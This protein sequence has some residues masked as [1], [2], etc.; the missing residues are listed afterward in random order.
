M[1]GRPGTGGEPVGKWPVGHDVTAIVV[2]YRSAATIEACLT[3]LEHALDP[4]S[5]EIIVVDNAS[6]DDTTAVVRTHLRARLICR[7]SNAGFGTAVNDGLRRTRT[8]YALV[9]NDDAEVDGACVVRLVAALAPNP[10]IGLVGPIVLDADG[11]ALASALAF[12]PG[13]LE[14]QDRFGRAARRL[15]RLVQPGLA[16]PTPRGNPTITGEEQDVSWLVGVALL[17]RSDVLRRLGG[18]NQA[19]FLYG[20]EID[21]GQRVAVAG[22]RNVWVTAATC[23]HPVGVGTSNY[24]WSRRE[25]VLRRF[26][27]QTTYDRI[28]LARRTRILL[29]LLR[30]TARSDQPLRA[31]YHLGAA[32]WDGP[33]LSDLRTLLPLEPAWPESAGL[34]G[35]NDGAALSRAWSPEGQMQQAEAGRHVPGPGAVTLH[36]Q[37]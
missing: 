17:G 24:I 22:L 11:N 26:R 16:P 7:E 25:R 12:F 29:N 10:D 34:G 31:S 36:Q 6:D 32:L 23:G 13:W 27:G 2:T 3:R 8:T 37:R 15:R 1:I 4:D 9:M 30:A 33:D 21:L 20:E 18:F 35:A 28:W 14:Q 5:S 19:F